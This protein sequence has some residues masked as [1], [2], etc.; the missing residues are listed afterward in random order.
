MEL[1]W[2]GGKVDRGST[3]NVMWYKL[4]EE[5][6]HGRN[7]GLKSGPTEPRALGPGRGPQL[8]RSIGFK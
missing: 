6:T 8:E 5:E 1:E 7:L 4:S 2:A 3:E